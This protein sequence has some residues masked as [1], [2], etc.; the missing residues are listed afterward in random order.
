MEDV[1]SVSALKSRSISSRLRK[2]AKP[3]KLWYN[4]EIIPH[5]KPTTEGI[6]SPK[7]D[8]TSSHI[9]R[10]EISKCTP[11]QQHIHQRPDE[12]STGNR[13]LNVKTTPIS[14]H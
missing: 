4:E 13:K 8:K 12:Q 9:D 6:D 11:F 3:R 2:T 10:A 5:K 14:M 7:E 1:G